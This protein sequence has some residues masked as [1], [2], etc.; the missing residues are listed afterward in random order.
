MVA[1]LNARN[2]PQTGRPGS[3]HVYDPFDFDVQIGNSVEENAF[4]RG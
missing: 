1:A 4:R 2:L 3:W